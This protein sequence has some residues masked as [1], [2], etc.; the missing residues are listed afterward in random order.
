MRKFWIVLLSLGLI[1]AFVMPAAAQ[2]AVKFGGSYYV[3]GYHESNHSL[4]DDATRAAST[5]FQGASASFFAQ[6]LRIQPEFKIAEGLTLVTRFDA[7]EKKWGDQTWSPSASYD[8][9][10]RLAYNTSAAGVRTQENIEWE[11]AY[12]DFTTGI[13][14]FMVGYQNFVAWG[15]S[16]GDTHITRPGIK[17]MLPMGD[18]TLVAA[19]EKV[20]EGSSTLFGT[21]AANRY[22]EHDY[23][24]YDLGLIG[25]F[26]GGEWGVLVQY[27]HNTVPEETASTNY[28]KRIYLVDPYVKATFG[29]IYFEAEAAYAW[30]DWADYAVA[31]TQDIDVKAMGIYANVKVD[32][33]P[34]Y[35]GLKFAWVRGD[36]YTTRDVEG[37]VMSS[38]LAGQVFNP[39]L[40]MFNDDLNSYLS[41]YNGYATGTNQPMTNF[42]DNAWLYQVY[43]GFKFTPKLELYASLSMAK[44]DEKPAANWVDKDFGTELDVTLTYKIFNNLSYM[45]GAGYWWVGDYFKGTSATNKIDDT[46][47]L[48]HK[49]TLTF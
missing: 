3:V 13:G 49:L 39:C 6:R 41:N 27:A 26:K 43:G 22:A 48:M 47:L 33:A 35:V 28:T 7:L 2:T 30:G 45:I 17:Y 38:L 25:K 42:F 18:L 4:K 1:M 19:W 20:G 10:N 14:R 11:R 44:A 12:V 9:S 15:T 5:S 8:V 24:I 32:L 23:N 21:S 37:N 40:M 34:A 46:Y 36:D 29:S 31:T 16:F